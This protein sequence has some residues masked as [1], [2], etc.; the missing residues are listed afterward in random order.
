MSSDSSTIFRSCYEET[1]KMIFYL[2]REQRLFLPKKIDLFPSELP[3]IS[4]LKCK[5]EK[6]CFYSF[7][8]VSLAGSNKIY[9]V[10]AWYLFSI[11]QLRTKVSSL[12]SMKRSFRQSQQIV[13]KLIKFKFFAMGQSTFSPLCAFIK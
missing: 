2:E 11:K 6:F 9:Y 1:S 10:D 8:F 5:L 13:E 3:E 7:F 4:S 12:R